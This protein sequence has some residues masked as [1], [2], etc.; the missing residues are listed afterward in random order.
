MS[1]RNVLIN[2]AISRGLTKIEAYTRTNYELQ[3]FLGS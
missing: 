2:L 3:Q 1:Y